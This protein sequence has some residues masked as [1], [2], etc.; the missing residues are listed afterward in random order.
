[1][2]CPRIYELAKDHGTTYSHTGSHRLRA[3]GMHHVDSVRA[4]RAK[5]QI[6]TQTV[7][8]EAKEVEEQPEGAL[9][10]FG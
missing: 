8:E 10:E 1:M 6:D 2:P 7:E 5:D 9:H 3:A 4:G